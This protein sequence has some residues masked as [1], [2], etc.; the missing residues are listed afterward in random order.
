MTR[1][2]PLS[3]VKNLK[4]EGAEYL[5]AYFKSFDA[6]ADIKPGADARAVEANKKLRAEQGQFLGALLQGRHYNKSGQQIKK[7]GNK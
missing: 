6:S 3:Y 7:K 5:N 4:K 2:S 1:I